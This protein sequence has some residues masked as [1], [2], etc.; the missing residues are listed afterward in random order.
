[1]NFEVDKLPRV[2]VAEVAFENVRTPTAG[3]W[4][5]ISKYGVVLS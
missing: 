4:I 5:S 3:H 1:M 2:L